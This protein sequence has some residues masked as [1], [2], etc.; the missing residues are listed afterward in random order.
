MLNMIDFKFPQPNE[1]QKNL[2]NKSGTSCH[3]YTEKI[4]KSVEELSTV[5]KDAVKEK[6]IVRVRGSEHSPADHILGS[7]EEG[8]CNNIFLHK[9]VH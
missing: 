4:V 2:S 9:I 6:K 7:D 3:S 5:I 1:H 8:M